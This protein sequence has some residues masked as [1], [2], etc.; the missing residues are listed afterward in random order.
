MIKMTMVMLMVLMAALMRNEDGSNDILCKECSGKV[1]VKEVKSGE[2]DDEEKEEV[3]GET[4][5]ME[6]GVALM[7]MVI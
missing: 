5:P 3:E 1:K 4:D 6:E 2:A 7:K